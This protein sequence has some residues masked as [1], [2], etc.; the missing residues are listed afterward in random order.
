MV[1]IA[2]TRAKYAA[3]STDTH[4]INQ[5]DILRVVRDPMTQTKHLMRVTSTLKLK[6]AESKQRSL[7]RVTSTLKLKGA[8]SKQKSLSRVTSHI[9]FKGAV[10]KKKSLS[11]V[12]SH[13]KLKGAESKRKSLSRVSSQFQ[14]H[15]ILPKRNS[16]LLIYHPVPIET[17]GIP[18]II[19]L[20]NLFKNKN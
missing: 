10:S 3:N 7:S 4:F 5:P 11:R 15:G 16:S 1:N 12:S 6:G 14:L 19:H 9:K 8:E 20:R 18:S 2:D 17:S 13:L